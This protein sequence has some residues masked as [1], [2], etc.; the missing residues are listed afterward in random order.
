MFVN[1]VVNVI[2]VHCLLSDIKRLLQ[3][4][5]QLSGLDQTILINEY[6]RNY[7]IIMSKYVS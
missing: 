6:Q 4:I 1:I 5:G 7:D 3:A 2:E